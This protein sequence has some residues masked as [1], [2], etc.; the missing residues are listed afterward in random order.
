MYLL[1]RFRIYN[2]LMIKDIS[3]VDEFRHHTIC[4]GF[5]KRRFDGIMIHCKIANPDLISSVLIDTQS[6]FLDKTYYQVYGINYIIETKKL[7]FQEAQYT[8]VAFIHTATTT[9]N[10]W[11]T[12]GF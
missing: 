2:N 12:D 11:I 10:N 4:S 1:F 6:V 3:F 8:L 5:I 9:E 7:W